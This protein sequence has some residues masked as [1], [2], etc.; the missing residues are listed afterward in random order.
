[1]FISFLGQFLKIHFRFTYVLYIFNNSRC[2]LQVWKYNYLSFISRANYIS[3]PAWFWR[4][5]LI[6]W[7]VSLNEKWALLVIDNFF[8]HSSCFLRLRYLIV[9]WVLHLNKPF[10]QWAVGEKSEWRRSAGWIVIQKFVAY[11]MRLWYFNFGKS[12]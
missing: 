7:D 12:S 8:S 4:H 11:M 10:T 6:Y 2:F 1:M 5:W 9:L 3:T